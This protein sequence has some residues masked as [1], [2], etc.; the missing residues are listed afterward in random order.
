MRWQDDPVFCSWLVS[1]GYA[2][3]EGKDTRLS[4]SLGLVLYMF[5]AYRLGVTRGSSV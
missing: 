2:R 3:K 5:E 1:Q 4:L